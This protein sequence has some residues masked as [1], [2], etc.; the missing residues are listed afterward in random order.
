MGNAT[1]Y[2]MKLILKILSHTSNYFTLDIDKIV[3][4]CMPEKAKYTKNTMETFSSNLSLQQ[5]KNG[6]K[7]TYSTITC[8]VSN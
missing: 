2:R 8:P 3:L 7:N 6:E 5:K 4:Y 1:Q